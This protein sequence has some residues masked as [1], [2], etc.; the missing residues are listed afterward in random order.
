MLA[1]ANADISISVIVPRD[2]NLIDLFGAIG[3]DDDLFSA[4]DVAIEATTAFEMLP[5]IS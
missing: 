5:F 2:L 4:T 3:T 1:S